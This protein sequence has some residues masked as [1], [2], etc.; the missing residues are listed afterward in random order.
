MP[1]RETVKVRYTGSGSITIAGISFKATK[2]VRSV[3]LSIVE[4]LKGLGKLFIIQTE[5][6]KS[7]DKIEQ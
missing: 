5:K 4:K 2:R 3:P 7:V 6:E 1:T